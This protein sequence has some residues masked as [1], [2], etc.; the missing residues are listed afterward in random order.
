[1]RPF[2]F[3]IALVLSS[4]ARGQV[5]PFSAA[6]RAG[7]PERD[8]ASGVATDEQGNI[9]MVG[10]IRGTA[11][12]G[13]ISVEVDETGCALSACPDGFVAMYAPDGTPLWVRRMG[14]ADHPDVANAVAFV[15]SYHQFY[16]DVLV[17]GTFSGEATWDG[18]S[19]P[20]VSLTSRGET[21]A[22]LAKYTASG[23]LV[24]VIQAGG[25]DAETG[26]GLAGDYEGDT[27]W[28]G[29]F[30]GT[31][32]IGSGEDASVL[33]SDGASDGFVARI[34]PDGALVW[35]SQI[36]GT[37]AADA[38][39]VVLGLNSDAPCV[40]GSFEG[41]VRFGSVALQSHGASDGYVA[42]LRGYN[43]AIDWVQQI[44]GDG[45]D[46]LRS[47][48][49][50]EYGEVAVAGG[51]FS[52]RVEIGQQVLA[53]AG[54]TDALVVAFDGYSGGLLWAARGGGPGADIASGVHIPVFPLVVT[55]EGDP[56]TDYPVFVSG[57]TEGTATFDGETPLT[58]EAEG[59]D[60]F[61]AAYALDA[62][63]G[64]QA[65]PLSALLLGGPG[66]DEASGVSAT[67]SIALYAPSGDADYTGF[68]AVVAGTFQDSVSTFGHPL[69]SVGGTDV[70]LAK[71]S[72]CSDLFC[73]RFVADEPT[74]E[75]SGIHL[76]VAPH[77][78]S[79]AG[80]TLTVALNTPSTLS[81]DLFDARGRRIAALTRGPHA[82][83]E[84]AFALPALAPGTYLLR[85]V[86][87]E[88]AV[89]E[90]L[91]VVR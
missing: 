38:F 65:R 76:S 79:G 40:V 69:Q 90:V 91:T 86:T 55:L 9:A 81:L 25:V 72:T 63:P 36:G 84:H 16:P 60:G 89:S 14:S 48:T 42:N 80:S 26:H 19:T 18:G 7:G 87:P 71:R 70:F 21:D 6:D 30:H 88:A 1:M 32:R 11:A 82:S 67:L 4:G 56:Q 3:L 13:P 62:S 15:G 61:L 85:A 57:Y 10:T 74:P 39:D 8:A 34:E 52:S 27:Y 20:D 22:F 17:S 64:A 44:G 5:G 41:E 54:E 28:T 23:D 46:R 83:G 47:V 35:I 78:A 73:F 37:G 50:S 45:D 68:Y 53:S 31:A 29:S 59:R 66:D 77:P 43:G 12:F 51:W 2:L 75:A 33:T 58:L 24:W 49:L